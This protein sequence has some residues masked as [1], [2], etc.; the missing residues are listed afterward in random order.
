MSCKLVLLFC[1]LSVAC[2]SVNSFGWGKEKSFSFNYN[3]APVQYKQVTY[4]YPAPPKIDYFKIIDSTLG[5]LLRIKQDKLNS[6]VR[7]QSRLA[8]SFRKHQQ[9]IAATQKPYTFTFTKNV[10]PHVL[11][12][13]VQ[14][15]F[16]YGNSATSGVTTTNTGTTSTSTTTVTRP[17][18]TQSLLPTYESDDKDEEDEEEEVQNTIPNNKPSSASDFV[19]INSLNNQNTVVKDVE[20]DD[21]E[22]EEAIPVVPVAPQAP[23]AP[24]QTVT[25]QRVETANDYLPPKQDYLPP[26]QDYLPPAQ[27]Y[28]PPKFSSESGYAYDTG[29]SSSNRNAVI[30]TRSIEPH[31]PIYIN[32][33][34]YYN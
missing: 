24:T 32:N 15:N 29:A 31:A 13:R 33:G 4:S 18:P 21:S 19:N 2:T 11:D 26:K 6:F 8:D 7:E 34:R 17:Q 10:V 1:V 22:E 5:V 28:L 16:N 9:T 25:N 12:V 23:V 27:S 20:D 14:G 3:P 30:V